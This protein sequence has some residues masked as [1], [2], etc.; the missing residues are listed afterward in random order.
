MSQLTHT[1]KFVPPKDKHSS[2][3]AVHLLG[4][5]SPDPNDHWTKPIV[6]SPV[7]PIQ[8]DSSDTPNSEPV[9]AATVSGL[10]PGK[11]YH[12]KFQVDDEWVCDIASPKSLD[13]NGF[14]NNVISFPLNGS[15]SCNVVPNGLGP[16]QTI[17][18]DPGTAPAHPGPAAGATSSLDSFNCLGTQQVATPIGDVG[19]HDQPAGNNENADVAESAVSH[20]ETHNASHHANDAAVPVPDQLSTKDY[21][22]A[23]SKSV[24]IDAAKEGHEIPA[25]EGAAMNGQPE[26]MAADS[27]DLLVI[28]ESEAEVVAAGQDDSKLEDAAET[29]TEAVAPVATNTDELAE[30]KSED[31]I[32]NAQERG[33]PAVE[34]N[35]EEGPGPSASAGE[36]DAEPAAEPEEPNADEATVPSELAE[37]GPADET[38]AE[39]DAETSA[40][41]EAEPVDEVKFGATTEPAIG[42]PTETKADG[43][44]AE[45]VEESKAVEAKDEPAARPVDELAEE[46]KAGKVAEPAPEPVED[47]HAGGP[48][49][50][51]VDGPAGEAAESVAEQVKSVEGAA[52]PT[53][54]PAAQSAEEPTVEEPKAEETVAAT[55]A[56]TAEPVEEAKVEEIVVE[57]EGS[58][59]KAPATDPVEEAKVDE[60]RAEE[61]TTEPE[62][63]TVE[64]TTTDVEVPATK[65]TEEAKAD[66]SKADKNAIEPE[67]PTVKEAPAA[68]PIA[69]ELVEEVK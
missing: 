58:T 45:P 46:A 26:A 59:V 54:E 68:K 30:S 37:V 44:T 39:G 38:H 56:S 8:D 66:E 25:I 65:S 14:E 28:A 51:G 11:N 49:P 48:E 19:L 21:A 22:V 1:F 41:P 2:P 67:E 20:V 32:A 50:E 34:A 64:E 43:P 60:S 31:A 3:K 15:N 4:T 29:V 6:L 16:E 53:T 23:D 24:P 17:A 5:F 55:E 61:T 47:K 18:Q 13:D 35:P 36:V 57:P 7:S 9:F 42:P 69:A 27:A 10:I 62:E 63:P 33:L 52:E 40:E 12:Y